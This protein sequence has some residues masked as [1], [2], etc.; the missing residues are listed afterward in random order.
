MFIAVDG[1][2]CLAKKFDSVEDFYNANPYVGLGLWDGGVEFQTL[3]VN[4]MFPDVQDAT[5]HVEDVYWLGAT[6]I[7]TGYPDGTFRP[8]LDVVRQDM[9]AFLYRLGRLW[10]I[11]DDNWQPSEK[12]EAAFSD[13]NEDTPHYREILWLASTGVSTGF[14]DGTFRP[15]HSV[16]RQDMAAFLHRLDGLS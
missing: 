3:Y 10:G 8:M 14:P 5:P 13:V 4:P 1:E 12:D 16:V 7:S 2:L 9:A 15:M 6:S 11:V